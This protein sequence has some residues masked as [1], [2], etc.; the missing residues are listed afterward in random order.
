MN[1][2]FKPR[3]SILTKIRKLFCLPEQ[4]LIS[5]LMFNGF[6]LSFAL[7]P[8]TTPVTSGCRK[9]CDLR[10]FQRKFCLSNFGK[11]PPNVY[12]LFFFGII[13][14]M[15][16]DKYCKKKKEKRKRKK[17]YDNLYMQTHR[18]NASMIGLLGN[19]KF[20]RRVWVQFLCM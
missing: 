6:F 9:R 7:E 11:D 12:K 4:N 2:C 1:I 18:C 15:K 19:S 14:G 5:R 16:N 20:L 10:N 13:M 8:K 3:D 17:R